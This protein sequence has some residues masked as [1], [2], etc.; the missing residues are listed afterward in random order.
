MG[1]SEPKTTRRYTHGAERAKRAAVEAASTRAEE[2]GE[3][4]GSLKAVAK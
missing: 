4:W 3:E 1:Y 2:G